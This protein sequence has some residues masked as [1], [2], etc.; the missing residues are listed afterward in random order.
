MRAAM[1]TAGTPF[2][3][4]HRY[5][6]L[7]AGFKLAPTEVTTITLDSMVASQRKRQRR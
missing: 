4:G 3:I 1:A 7:F 6:E 5:P 2:A